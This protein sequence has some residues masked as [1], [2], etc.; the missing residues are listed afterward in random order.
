MG[1][2]TGFFETLAQ[3]SIEVRARLKA[4]LKVEPYG[5]RADYQQFVRR[6]I[7]AMANLPARRQA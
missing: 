5:A 3:S 1:V 6:D 4:D 7:E 2:R